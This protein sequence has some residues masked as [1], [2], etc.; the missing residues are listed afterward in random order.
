M[1]EELH[2]VLNLNLHWLKE[3]RAEVLDGFLQKFAGTHAKAWSV[4]V[5]ERELE[6]WS[7]IPP[8]DKLTAYAGI[9][10]DYLRKRLRRLRR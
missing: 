8:G 4:P 1:R 5:V 6:K 7:T 9:V 2:D 3:A 10:V